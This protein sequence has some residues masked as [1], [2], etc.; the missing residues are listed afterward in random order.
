MS[1][2]FTKKGKIL[3]NFEEKHFNAYIN[4]GLRDRET[5]QMSYWTF[6]N[7]NQL[8]LSAGSELVETGESEVKKMNSI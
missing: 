6:F 5:K 7:F 2:I 4:D 1:S 8:L 3:Q